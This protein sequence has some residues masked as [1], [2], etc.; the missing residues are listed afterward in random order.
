VVEG[1]AEHSATLGRA[2]RVELARESFAATA[3]AMTPEGYLV[4]TRADGTEQV[5]TAGDVIHLRPA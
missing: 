4:V 2:V 1:A 5:V 3:T